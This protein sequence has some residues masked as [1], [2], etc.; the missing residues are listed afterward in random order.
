MTLG[1]FWSAA[2]SGLV[3]DFLFLLYGLALP[4]FYADCYDAAPTLL[5][6]LSL[7]APEIIVGA[8]VDA[9]AAVV[10]II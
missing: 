2:L 6:S 9:A 8:S 1:A 7:A 3:A 10:L 5:F 4:G